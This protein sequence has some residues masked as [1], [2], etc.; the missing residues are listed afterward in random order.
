MP[1]EIT[2]IL[3]PDEPVIKQR[4]PGTLKDEHSFIKRP[5]LEIL[6][7]GGVCEEDLRELECTPENKQAKRMFA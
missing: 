1:D 5:K 6:P 2:K 4:L 7:P 3:A